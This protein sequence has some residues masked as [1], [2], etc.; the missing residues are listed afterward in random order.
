MGQPLRSMTGFGEAN[1]PLSDRLEARVTVSSVNSRFLEIAL[2]SQPRLDLAEL[3]P[4]VR[5]TVGRHMARGRVQVQLSL[6]WASGGR[7]ELRL[8]W[9]AV[10]ALLG[11]LEQ[12]PAGFDLA[13]FSFRDL[14]A[15]PGFWTSGEEL[16]LTGEERQR[17]IV[18]V[19]EA[20]AAV[21]GEREREGAALLPQLRREADQLDAFA[22]WLGETNDS[23]RQVLT[24][25]LR[26]RLAALLDG[27][28]VVPEERILSEA[29]LGADRADV[30]EEVQRLSA[31][32]AYLRRL[33]A[34]GGVVGK[35]LDFLAQEMLREV[36]TAGSK[37]RDAGLAE[38]VVEAK[39]ALEKL[40]EQF[41]NLE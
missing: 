12:R 33:L 34:E 32:L 8:D 14:M 25:R 20:A 7:P 4:D 29:A 24:V 37:C 23:L 13:P 40:R 15:V 6:A 21:A 17:L 27:V 2:R 35:K 1:G 18:L 30:A 9:G 39:A 28:A 5:A 3:E 10:A 26:D 38:R 36:N 22:A 16:G 41:A 19:D 31:H 11:A